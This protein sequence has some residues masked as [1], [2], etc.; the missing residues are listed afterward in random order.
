MTQEHYAFR[1]I[2]RAV[3]M[4]KSILI[5]FDLGIWLRLALIALFAGG[6]AGGMQFSSGSLSFDDIGDGEFFSSVIPQ[7]PDALLSSLLLVTGIPLMGILIAAFF[8]VVTF[9]GLMASVPFVTFLRTYSLYVVGDFDDRYAL[10]PDLPSPDAGE[11][12]EAV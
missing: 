7:D 12:S 9:C 2:D 4:T 6:A 8:A 5:P 10:L 3:A 1:E 11:A